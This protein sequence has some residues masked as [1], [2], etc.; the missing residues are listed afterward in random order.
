MTYVCGGKNGDLLNLF[1]ILQQEFRETG[2]APHLVTTKQYGS[3]AKAFP[4]LRVTEIDCHFD[5]LGIL[6]KEAKKL[7]KVDFIPQCHSVGSYPQSKRVTPSFCLEAWEKCGRLHQWRELTLELPR[8][9]NIT[10]PENPFVLLA[11]HSQS[12]PAIFIERLFEQLSNSLPGFNVIRLSTIREQSLL[13]FLKLYDA[14]SLLVSIDTAHA[15]LSRASNVPFIMLST[16][17]PTTWHGTCYHPRMS[18]HVRYSDYSLRKSELLHV[19]KQILK[20][21]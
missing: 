13:D 2:I 6:V 10:I 19:A 18:L 1:P 5:H 7:G 8:T 4:N 16:D 17:S 20:T 21:Y 3:L 15:H 9:G 12:S 11:D 14:A